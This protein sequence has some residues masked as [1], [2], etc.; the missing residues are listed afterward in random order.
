MTAINRDPT[1]PGPVTELFDR[2][3]QLHLEAGRPSMRQIATRAGRGRI[4]SST[5]H[6]V[7]RSSR[8]PRW[9]FLEYIVTALHGDTAEFQALWQAAWQAENNAAVARVGSPDVTPS[10]PALAEFAT[11]KPPRRIWSTEIPS[12]N[13][14]FTGRL[15]EMEALRTNLELRPHPAAQVIS[16]MGGVG[17]TEIATEYIHRYRD[18]Y[19]IIWWIRAEH[20]DRVRDALVKLAQRL[21]VRP[22]G[23]ESGRDRTIAAVLHALASGTRQSWLLVFDNAAQP[24]ELQRYLPT[25]PPGGHIII[26]SRLQNWPGYLETDS[27]EVAPFTEDE[28]ISFLRRRVR[29]S[30]R[31]RDSPRARMSGESARRDAWRIRL[32]I[33]PSRS[34]MPRLT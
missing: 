34:S 16:G 2:L 15:V 3:D 12:R 25:C 7:F 26:T 28:A 17:K 20:H 9:A 31:T 32:G 14:D 10:S 24:L 22:A 29:L 30:V 11:S 5:V 33:C 6:N 27:I 19:E 18:R 4:S 21:E 13:L 1:P 23:T 8:V